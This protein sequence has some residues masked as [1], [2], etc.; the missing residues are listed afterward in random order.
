MG[1][2][3][4]S[5]VLQPQAGAANRRSSRQLTSLFVEAVVAGAV[6][7]SLAMIAVPAIAGADGGLTFYVG[8]TT[9]TGATSSTCQ[10]QSNTTC[11]IDDAI[12][13]YNADTVAQADTIIVPGNGTT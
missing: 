3:L 11:G 1:H 7:A 10:S 4:N 2:S 9:D 8:S 5:G 13:A 12:A 6:F